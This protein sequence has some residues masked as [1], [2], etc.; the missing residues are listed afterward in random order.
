MQ[1]QPKSLNNKTFSKFILLTAKLIS[2]PLNTVSTIL[3][4][5]SVFLPL[6]FK[7]KCIINK[8]EWMNGEIFVYCGLCKTEFTKI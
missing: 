5:L 7:K 6:A 1:R 2:M 8:N 4:E 3:N